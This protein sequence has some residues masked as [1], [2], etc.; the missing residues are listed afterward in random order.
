M[1]SREGTVV[2]ADDLID[3]L[4]ADAVEEIKT[5]GREDELDDVDDVAEKVALAAL[6]YYLLQITPVKD[7]LFNPEESLS[8]NGN[9]GPYLQSNTG[10]T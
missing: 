6:N 7:M 10:A 4:H 3:Q 8:F 9:T 1:K 2:D 5:K